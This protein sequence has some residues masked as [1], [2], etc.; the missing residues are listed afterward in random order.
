MAK[1]KNSGNM[2]K[3]AAKVTILF[4]FGMIIASLICMHMRGVDNLEPLRAMN[5]GIDLVG[6][7]I[8]FVIL[9]SCYVDMQRV[10]IDYKYFRYLVESTFIG[11]FMDIGAWLMKNRPDF[12]FLN[13]L[14][15]SLFFLTM[16]ATVF[17]FWRYRRKCRI[18]SLNF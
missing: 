9:L 15:N 13:R 10:G 5:V 3:L 14:D 12:W 16:P 4:D 11:L 8:G 17:F 2:R 6:M 7:I 18:N 1:D